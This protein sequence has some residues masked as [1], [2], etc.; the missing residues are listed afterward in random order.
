METLNKVYF[1]ND[2]RGVSIITECYSIPE[3][4]RNRIKTE[5]DACFNSITEI[6]EESSSSAVVTQKQDVSEIPHD[7]KQDKEKD[8]SCSRKADDKTDMFSDEFPGSRQYKFTTSGNA[9]T[10]M[11]MNHMVLNKTILHHLS[12]NE[13]FRLTIEYEP[14]ELNARYRIESDHKCTENLSI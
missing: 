1:T 4:L 3:D 2:K 12:I 11:V 5:L 10:R 8:V 6:L 13:P 9:K 7:A 14:E